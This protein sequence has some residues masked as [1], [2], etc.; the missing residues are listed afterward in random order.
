MQWYS[1]R[2]PGTPVRLESRELQC[3][4][5]REEISEADVA[6]FNRAV[7]AARL[8]YRRT[9][10]SR[11]SQPPTQRKQALDAI[12]KTHTKIALAKSACGSTAVIAQ[13][14]GAGSGATPCPCTV[15]HV[16]H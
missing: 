4:T 5:G 11:A 16:S 1:S 2:R 13:P 8:D 7:P 12:L 15:P 14:S 9:A 3:N 6:P 10:G